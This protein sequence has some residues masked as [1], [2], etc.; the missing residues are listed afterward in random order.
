MENN[1]ELAARLADCE[2]HLGYAFKNRELLE[3][4]LTHASDKAARI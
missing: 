3:L 2:Q 4:A 1:A